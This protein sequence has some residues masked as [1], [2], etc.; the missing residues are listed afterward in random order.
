MELRIQHCPETTQQLRH[1]PSDITLI[2]ITVSTFQVFE[3][4]SWRL[5]KN[6]V[7]DNTIGF[8]I[9]KYERLPLAR[10]CSGSKS[11]V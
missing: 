1:Y 11:E 2:F 10:I 6:E 5:Q 3:Q 8:P 4:H 7:V 9:T